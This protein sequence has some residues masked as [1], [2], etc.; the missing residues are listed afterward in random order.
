MSLWSWCFITAIEI[1]TIIYQQ[2]HFKYVLR[3]TVYTHA[4][5]GAQCSWQHYLLI[6][7]TEKHYKCLQPNESI[8]NP[9]LSKKKKKKK[10]IRE[11]KREVNKGEAQL[12]FF[13][14]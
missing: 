8:K 12:C 5:N 6:T 13:W 10:K 2:F 14:V 1:L 7:K 11:G 9:W 3:R 4:K